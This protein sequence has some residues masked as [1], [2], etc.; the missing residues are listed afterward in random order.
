MCLQV[1]TWVSLSFSGTSSRVVVVV[2]E[3]EVEAELGGRVLLL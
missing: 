1:D 3:V 2:L